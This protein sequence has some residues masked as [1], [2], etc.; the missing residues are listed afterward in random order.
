MATIA[1]VSTMDFMGAL[2]I[3]STR[4]DEARNRFASARRK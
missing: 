1:M 2:L 3:E 4:F